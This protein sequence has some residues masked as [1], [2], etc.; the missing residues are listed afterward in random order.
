MTKLSLTE[1]FTSFIIIALSG[2][3]SFLVFCIDSAYPERMNKEASTMLHKQ[4]QFAL[5]RFVDVA[6]A[7]RT[8]LTLS[9]LTIA[10]KPKVND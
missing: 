9:L 5:E 8:R 2:M 3:D 10:E 6:A 1:Q 7:S 4:V